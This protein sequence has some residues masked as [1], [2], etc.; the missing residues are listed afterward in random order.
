[1]R[2]SP[3]GPVCER[4]YPPRPQ[5]PGRRG[6]PPRSPCE[7]RLAARSGTRPQAP[8]LREPPRS[9]RVPGRTG[10]VV[11]SSVESSRTISP[12]S[13]GSPSIEWTRSR[14]GAPPWASCRSRSRRPTSRRGCATPHLVDVDDNRFRDRGP[15]RL[16]QGLARDPLPL[17]DLARRWPASSATASRSSSWSARRRP[18]RRRRPSRGRRAAGAALEPTRVGGEGAGATNLNPRYTFANFIVGSANRL[19]HAASRCRS[20]S[21][22]GTPTT[23][24]SCTAASAS[25]RPT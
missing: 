21:G 7:T 15:Q 17:A 8:A 9:P 11:R 20:P 19:A 16:R 25:A 24:S 2:R 14:S 10:L 18:R 13:A 5:A 22:P 12:Q 1:M 6:G 23:R 4:C 3:C